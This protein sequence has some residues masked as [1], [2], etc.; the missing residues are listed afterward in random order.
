MLDGLQIPRQTIVERV[1]DELRQRILSGTIRPGT[2]LTE[3][4]LARTIGVSRNTV[5]EV[6]AILASE[7][8][9]KRSASRRVLQ[10]TELSDEDVAD[11]FAA[12]RPLELAAVDAAATASPEAWAR[13]EAATT[14]YSAA[15]SGSDVPSI[16]A[17]DLECHIAVVAF[18]ASRRLTDM[19]E[20][21]MGELRLAFAATEIEE[22]TQ[23]SVH[24]EFHQLLLAGR[25]PEARAHLARRLDA[26]EAQ[27]R[28]LVRAR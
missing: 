16:V 7:G 22:H 6:L 2:P 23:F 8:L 21:M 1:A 17:A 26:A 25:F 13:F 20:S 5:R 4:A 24:E 28:E 12:R 15:I 10:V 3:D 27:L 14:A 9:L 18:L 19:Y 11:I